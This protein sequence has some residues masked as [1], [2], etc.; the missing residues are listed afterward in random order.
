MRG[1]FVGFVSVALC[2]AACESDHDA[3]AQRA[4]GGG[5]GAKSSGG[6]SSASGGFTVVG[7]GGGNTGAS[8]GGRAP[9]E[10]PGDDVFTFLHGIVD[11]ER[12]AVCFVA[13]QGAT[14]RTLGVP[15]PKGGLGFGERLVVPELDGADFAEDEI[16]P[17]V[18][19]GELARVSGLD[20][21]AALELA[22]AEQAKGEAVTGSGGT[23][24][25]G[26]QGGALGNGGAAGASATGD[27]AG[28]GGA[29]GTGAEGGAA[30]S[31]GA[32]GAELDLPDPPVL[33]VGSLPSMPVGTLSQGRSVLFVANGCIGGPAF[34]GRGEQEACGEL[35]TPRAATLSAVVV[36]LSRRASTIALGLQAVHASLGTV[37]WGAVDVVSEQTRPDHPP[38]VYVGS[39]AT[40]GGVAPRVPRL[41]VSN[42]LYG[43]A[44]SDG[45]LAV[46]SQWGLL[47][48]EDWSAILDR[49]QLSKLEDG[50]TYA[51]VL[52]G[53]S[54][55]FTP[56]GL[57]NPPAIAVVPTDPTSM[58]K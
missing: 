36:P 49:S 32:G 24:G 40:L 48:T 19:A 34:S 5:G 38:P 55:S 27:T 6:A 42:E 43:T 18:I 57:W 17:V 30:G 37:P 3:L 11:A 14:R 15:A 53:P 4:S 33:R 46:Y 10:P 52:I 21:E 45:R 51:L 58:Q 35:Y 22:A 12:V 29:G 13:G 47:F 28:M 16:Q 7:R 50:S 20:C 9:D 39:G 41:D 8:T 26:G 54:F 2:V 25:A 1:W 56:R 31:G 23:G 44:A